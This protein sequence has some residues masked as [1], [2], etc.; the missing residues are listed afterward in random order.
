MAQRTGRRAVIHGDGPLGRP[1]RAAAPGLLGWAGWSTPEDMWSTPGIFVCPSFREAF[2]R[3]AV[4][5]ASS[6]MPVILSDRTGVAPMLIRDR[7]LASRF[8]VPAHDIDAWLAAVDELDSDP[9]LRRRLSD[10]VSDNARRLGT[11]ASLDG[12]LAALD[13]LF[14]RTP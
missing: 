8:I 2:G 6:G 5:A 1:L 11:E 3:S 14:R 10:H 9:D 13:Q 4:E 7:D 12:A